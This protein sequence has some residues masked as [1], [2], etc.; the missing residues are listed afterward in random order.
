MCPTVYDPVDFSTPCLPVLHHIPEFAQVRAL[1]FGDAIQ[2]AHPLTPKDI[3][4]LILRI[5][6][7][8]ILN[9]KQRLVAVVNLKLLTQCRL[10]TGFPM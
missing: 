2:P 3:H 1:C 6:V 5:C 8:V 4:I 9:C 10:Y 7:Y